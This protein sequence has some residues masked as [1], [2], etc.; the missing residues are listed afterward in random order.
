VPKL[1]QAAS[2]LISGDLIFAGSVG[3]AF[4]CQRRLVENFRRLISELPENTVIAPGHG[5]L[6]TIKNERRFNPFVL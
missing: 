2:L 1:T 5:P 4:Y 6:T 3:G